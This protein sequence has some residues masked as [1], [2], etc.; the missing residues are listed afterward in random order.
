CNRWS[1]TSSSDV[2]TPP[3]STSYGYLEEELAEIYY[4]ATKE[5]LI[6][7]VRYV[8]SDSKDIEIG[9]STCFHQEP[10]LRLSCKSE[11][12]GV[13]LTVEDWNNLL[14]W[15]PYTEI[16]L[17]RSKKTEKC[18]SAEDLIYEDVNYE[19]YYEPLSD[20]LGLLYNWKFTDDSDKIITTIDIRQFNQSCCMHRN[21]I[22]ELFNMKYAINSR[23]QQLGSYNFA[24]FYRIFINKMVD[25]KRSNKE[26]API[27]DVYEDARYLIN[28][29]CIEVYFRKMCLE[30]IL[31]YNP[32]IIAN[33]V[34]TKL[35]YV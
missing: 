2:A 16:Q 21:E 24:T 5:T 8:L 18:W 6:G 31:H 4:Q 27:A 26:T 11:G 23:L 14:K 7:A 34:M 35:Q 33:D 30:E 3:P 25:L 32:S 17:Y 22:E 28:Q 9:Y 20:T 19:D 10:V 15:Q 12:C 1:C 29:L 13:I